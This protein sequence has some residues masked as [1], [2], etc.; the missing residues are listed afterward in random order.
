M[1]RLWKICIWFFFLIGFLMCLLVIGAGVVIFIL[2]EQERDPDLPDKIVLSLTLDKMI[3]E[4]GGPLLSFV[5]DSSLTLPA[6][7]Q[8]M[9]QAAQD[10]RVAGIQINIGGQFTSFSQAQELR[11]MILL[12]RKSGKQVLVY[13]DSFAS[14]SQGIPYYIAST[15]DQIWMA[16]SGI[17]SVPGFSIEPMFVKML[18]EKYGITAEFSQ[19]KGYKTAPNIFLYDHLTDEHRKSLEKLTDGLT[20]QLVSGIASARNLTVSKIYALLFQEGLHS[21]QAVE[22][23]LIDQLGYPHDVRDHWQVDEETEFVT[24]SAYVGESKSEAKQKAYIA[25]IVAQGYI[26]S[27]ES[28]IH[29]L[30]GSQTIGSKTILNNLTDLEKHILSQ[31]EADFDGQEIKGVLIRINSPGGSYIASDQIYAK[32]LDFKQKVNVPV[33][34]SMGQV[35]ASGGYFIAMGADKVF[36]LSGTLTGSIG[37]YGGKISFEKLLHDQGITSGKISSGPYAGILSPLRGLSAVQRAQLEQEMDWIYADFV[38]KAA[39]QRDMSVNEL[40]QFAQGRVWTGDDAA[41][42]QLID[43]I[44]GFS[45]VLDY[46]RDILKLSEDT[47]LEL[48]VQNQG[49]K[50]FIKESLGGADVATIFNIMPIELLSLIFSQEINHMH[51]AYTTSAKTSLPMALIN[52]LNVLSPT[53]ALSLAPEYYQLF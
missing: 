43:E 39:Q 5:N 37:V 20:R 33:V 18:F 48:V 16:P 38:G 30:I 42:N 49:L 35:A 41:E 24:M 3:E 51:K 15:A 40:E 17:V 52:R 7:A 32:I 53:M 26:H 23:D 45:D 36:A 21:Q 29:P 46:Y 44:G 47:E 4:D 6:L 28:T 50:N 12:F 10:Q 13:S 34:I 31:K 19:R 22:M 14:S 27:G 1:K 9:Q 8:A 25:Y 11:N 2:H